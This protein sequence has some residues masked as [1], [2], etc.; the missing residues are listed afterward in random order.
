MT[1]IFLGGCICDFQSTNRPDMVP[2]GS[3]LLVEHLGT[4]DSPLQVHKMDPSRRL[5]KHD[6]A[7]VLAIVKKVC[8]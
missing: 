4:D 3:H 1:T 2:T 5:P 8:Y 7:E 6:P